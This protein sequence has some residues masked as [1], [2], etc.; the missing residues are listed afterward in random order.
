[1]QNLRYSHQVLFPR[2]TV[3]NSRNMKVLFSIRVLRELANK[4]A[5]FFLPV[6]L[7]Q[8]GISTRF[9]AAW[10]LTS[11]QSGVVLLALYFAVAKL[12][13]VLLAIPAGDFIRRYGFAASLM[14]SHLL[15]AVTLI[16]FRLALEN[17]NWLW[18]AIATDGVN[19]TLMWGSFNT[20]FSKD[21]RKARMGRELGLI[22]AL[23]N[24]I[25]MIAP[26]VSGIV[27][28]MFGYESLFSAGL[29]IVGINILLAAFVTAARERDDVSLKEFSW[30]IRERRFV[31]LSASIGGKT[32]HDLA[33]FVWPLYVFLLL[34]NTER[35]GIL[36]SLSFLLSVII[37]LFLSERIDHHHRRR[38]FYISGGM[39]SVLWALRSQVF[40]PWAIALV[41]T[42]DKLTGNYH[43]LF[44]DRL[45]FNRG[46]GRAALSYFIYR[47]FI[48]GVSA[49]G[50]W[51]LFALIFLIWPLEW[52]GLFAL[53]AVGVLLTL[54]VNKK[55]ETV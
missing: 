14:L 25:W 9:L 7:F 10:G 46:K 13:V 52:R 47:E 43:W 16:G 21:A 22:Q 23:L 5:L 45:L 2:I 40:T 4:L 50:F 53:A 28:F 12:M 44:F 42:F 55:H 41:D 48:V 24:V 27:I 3:D 38:P 11:F 17:L 6:F 39:L 31:K 26:A 35:V 51:L 1:M 30:W 36:Y 32:I 34:G 8:L 15:Y 18:L 19:S 49:M 33:I 54:L 29:V 20:L 37:E